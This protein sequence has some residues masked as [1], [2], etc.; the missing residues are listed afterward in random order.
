[1]EVAE[2]EMRVRSLEAERAA[3]RVRNEMD[4]TARKADTATA[5]MSA[6]FKKVGAA[7]TSMR[8]LLAG[9]GA[10]LILRSGIRTIA[11]FE[12]AMANARAAMGDLSEEG[13][14]QLRAEARKLGAETV[15]SAQQ[16]AEAIESLG[17]AGFSVNEIMGS[18]RGTLDLAA[19]GTLEMGEAAS[20]TAKVI[21]GMGLEAAD[22]GR[23]ANV[24]AKA[25]TMAD[26]DVR[27][28]GDAMKFA[29]PQGR[30]LGAS[31]EETVAAVSTFAKA[32]IEAGEAGT[33]FRSAMASLMKLTPRA[34]KILAEHGIAASEVNPEIQGMSKAFSRLA[35]AQLTATEMAA[36][37][38][39][40][41]VGAVDILSKNVD[42]L[43]KVED[44]TKKRQGQKKD[45]FPIE[46]SLENGIQKIKGLSYGISIMEDIM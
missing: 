30:L 34:T 3:K 21:G 15:F 7:I 8:G 22:A 32:G 10:F 19:A 29:G 27:T 26:Q 6:G 37:F 18:L 14:Q 20:I 45:F 16:A 13:F 24:L 5:R 33:Y 46:T 23:V 35:E 12:Q 44:A 4:K 1:M 28:L 36:M 17:K 43:N 41:S 25:A 31:L 2:L 39:R 38:E 9:F 11:Q 40:R 42:F